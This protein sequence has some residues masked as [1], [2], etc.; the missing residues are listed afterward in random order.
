MD[1]LPSSSAI[2]VRFMAALNGIFVPRP[3]LGLE[4]LSGTD[5]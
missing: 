3:Q 5:R 4:E 1:M 2:E